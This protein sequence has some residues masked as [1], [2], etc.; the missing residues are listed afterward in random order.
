VAATVNGFRVGIDRD[1]RAWRAVAKHCSDSIQSKRR[2]AQDFIAG[3]TLHTPSPAGTICR[4]TSSVSGCGGLKRAFDDEARAVDLVQDY[5]TALQDA[6]R[7][8]EGRYWRR[9]S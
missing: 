9:N 5:R 2:V 4:A 8:A 6:M 7:S 3:E 1:C